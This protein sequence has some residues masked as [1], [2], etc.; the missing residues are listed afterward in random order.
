MP[1]IG[2]RVARLRIANGESLREAAQRTGVS[3]STIA[4]IE[5]GEVTASLDETLRKVAEGY[6]VPLEYLL[7]GKHRNRRNPTTPPRCVTPDERATLLFTPG[8]ERIRRAVA[9]VTRQKP[10]RLTREA[11][12]ASLGLDMLGLDQV[13]RGE[14]ET[15][16]TLPIQLS[17]LTG[18][19]PLWF[20]WA[21]RE[22]EMPPEA[23]RGW[24]AYFR[25]ARKV[26]KSG[27][28]PQLVEM[29]IDLLRIQGNGSTEP[30]TQF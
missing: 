24:A 29:A 19:S 22:G 28:E 15:P 30:T 16:D 4:R 23:L 10:G 6:G 18:L 2:S 17:H 26:S 27:L 25:L 13:L 8:R 20:E 1:N 14:I 5:K 21:I 3:H 7:T 9:M 11:L 12:A